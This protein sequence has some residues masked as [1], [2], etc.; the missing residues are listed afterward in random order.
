MAYQYLIV[1]LFDFIIAPTLTF[2]LSKH[3]G[4][5]YKAWEPL[6][7]KEGGYYHMAM[8]AVLGVAAWTRGL[9][10][11]KELDLMSGRETEIEKT[12]VTTKTTSKA[13]PE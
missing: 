7:L 6:T 12:K 8:G 11:I 13:D 5:A 1:C 4:I 10:K 3:F 9:E 2:T